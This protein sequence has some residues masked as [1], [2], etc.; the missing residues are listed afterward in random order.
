EKLT[1]DS[2]EGVDSLLSERALSNLRP[3]LLSLFSFLPLKSETDGST[4]EGQLFDLLVTARNLWTEDIQALQ[5]TLSEAGVFDASLKDL[6]TE[7]DEA[8]VDVESQLTFLSKI[9]L[10]V[11]DMKRALDLKDSSDSLQTAVKVLRSSRGVELPPVGQFSTPEGILG[12]QLGFEKTNVSAFSNT[13]FV[14][15]ILADLEAALTAFS[16]QLLGSYDSDRKDDTSPIKILTTLSTDDDFTFTPASVRS[17]TSNLLT[18]QFG[19]GA[20]TNN[21]FDP[22]TSSDFADFLDSLP[23]DDEDRIKIL[24]VALSRELRMSAGIKLMTDTSLDDAYSVETGNLISRIVGNTG[25]KITDGIPRV[26]TLA[27]ISR[28]QDDTG[29]VVLP[30]EDR[31]VIDPD[32]EKTFV[33]GTIF[34]VDS[35]LRG[36]DKFET[37]AL[38]DYAASMKSTV[39]NGSSAIARLLNFDDEHRRLY[40]ITVFKEIMSFVADSIESLVKGESITEEQALGAALLVAAQTDPTLKRQLFNYLV[41]VRAG[42]Y[43][44]ASTSDPS[45]GGSGGAGGSGGGRVGPGLGG[46]DLDGFGKEAAAAAAEA[47]TS[48]TSFGGFK[49]ANPSKATSAISA[50]KSTAIKQGSTVASMVV[51][52]TPASIESR[53]EALFSSTSTT[54][55][56]LGHSRQTLSTSSAEA[57][58]TVT[59]TNGTITDI[60][61]AGSSNDNFIFAKMADYADAQL[62]TATLIVAAGQSQRYDDDQTKTST[63]LTRMNR[64]SDDTLLLLLFEV[65]VSFYSAFI[66]V[67]FSSASD[68]GQVKISVNKSKCGTVRSKMLSLSERISEASY[69]DSRTGTSRSSISSSES[70]AAKLQ[71]LAEV[72][73]AEEALIRDQ[74]DM[75]RAISSTLHTQAT[76]T[77]SFFGSSSSSSTGKNLAALLA[78]D[79]G[80]ALVEGLSNMQVVLGWKAS[81][82]LLLSSD[83]SLLPDETVLT[84]SEINSVRALLA[85]PEFVSPTGNN[86]KILSVGLPAGLLSSL[87][88]PTFTVGEDTSIE[89]TTA[90]LVTVKIYRL[91]PEFEDLV[92]KPRSFVFDM[93]RFGINRIEVAEDTTLSTVLS[94]GYALRE[95][96]PES[97]LGSPDTAA[98]LAQQSEYEDLSSIEIKSLVRNHVV[99]ELLRLYIKILTGMNFAEHTFLVDESLLDVS[100]TETALEFFETF[101]ASTNV[102]CISES[103]S[104][105]NVALY[106]KGLAAGLSAKK[107]M[108]YAIQNSSSQVAAAAKSSSRTIPSPSSS[109]GTCEADAESESDSEEA[110]GVDSTEEDSDV[111]AE[112]VARFKRLISSVFFN[113]TS[114]AVRT[115]QT[116]MFERTFLVP[117]DPDDFEIDV[118]ETSTTRAGKRLLSSVVF[119]NCTTEETDSDGST[120]L[121]LVGREMEF[122]EF[123]S[124]ISLGV[125]L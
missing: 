57:S 59:L 87:Q 99:H 64:L 96:N 25:E 30:F 43:V 114:L 122:S 93:S 21:L 10:T 12:C 55:K 102:S 83:D 49:G 31:V 86:L 34:L 92:F 72:F 125:D 54:S 84:E 6:Q 108:S 45:G 116:K 109:S 4:T 107:A 113:K 19:T 78:S 88:H 26:G 1:V 44:S 90:D 61:D 117:V 8:V 47:E 56:S 7:Y 81:E 50:I 118:D 97:G 82:D 22:T 13:K 77:A 103:A 112:L 9:M 98:V 33:P 124:V 71:A 35:I 46:I 51:R 5:T 106:I 28:F 62:A 60:L 104:N 27:S 58:R 17:Q 85:E 37:T 65:V 123:F 3:E 75:L 38:D 100:Y 39:E 120:V 110:E 52:G 48:S 53:V 23:A 121:K 80:N 15:Q 89:S 16:P 73:E 76:S 115:L 41:A 66:D 2:P 14:G 91:D 11:N 68:S 36:E 67:K 74:V 69:L 79:E 101:L 63:G 111:D 95:V 94:T 32:E 20:L 40:Y 29:N 42:D 18:K 70:S 105:S 119:K 24:I